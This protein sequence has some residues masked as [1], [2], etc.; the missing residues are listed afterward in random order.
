MLYSLQCKLQA[1]KAIPRYH[2][3]PIAPFHSVQV[4]TFSH[5]SFFARYLDFKHTASSSRL[6]LSYFECKLMSTQG[7]GARVGCNG[8]VRLSRDA[9]DRCRSLEKRD[10]I[11]LELLFASVIFTR[12]VLELKPRY[13]CSVDKFLWRG[14]ASGSVGVTQCVHGSAG[15]QGKFAPDNYRIGK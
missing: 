11:N 9:P 6:L 8:P 15:E 2:P 14:V 7:R 4:V 5:S 10:W 3:R 12:C 1:S 13:S